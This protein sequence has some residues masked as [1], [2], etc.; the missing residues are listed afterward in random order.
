[1]SLIIGLEDLLA[2]GVALITFKEELV[3]LQDT[4]LLNESGVVRYLRMIDYLECNFEVFVVKV[5]WN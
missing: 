5:N 2:Q 1:M 4:L 3:L